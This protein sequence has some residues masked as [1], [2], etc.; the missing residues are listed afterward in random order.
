MITPKC[1]AFQIYWEIVGSI[2]H[3]CSNEVVQREESPA[4]VISDTC[5]ISLAL[6]SMLV[7]ANRGVS[8]LHCKVLG[9]FVKSLNGFANSETPIPGCVRVRQSDQISTTVISLVSILMNPSSVAV[10]NWIRAS[11]DDL[12]SGRYNW[13]EVIDTLDRLYE[14]SIC[15]YKT[16]RRD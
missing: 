16:F 10:C 2:S 9:V 14:G 15:D 5:V 6:R 12:Q 4:F 13:S 7:F 3:Q 1:V 8:M 11:S